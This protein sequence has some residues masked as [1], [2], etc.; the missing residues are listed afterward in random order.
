MATRPVMLVILDGFGWREE[1]ADN[2]V[3]QAKTPTFTRLWESGPHAFLRTSGRDVGLPDGQMGNS[4]VGHLNIGAGRVVKQ[5]LVRIGDA[6]A[7]GSIAKMPAFTALVDALN[8]SGGTC[9]LIGLVSPGGVHSHQDHAA[10]IA[11]YLHKAGIR[12]V[13]HAITDGRDTPPQSAAE[14]LRRL[15]SALPDDVPVATVVGRY[16][17][18][19]RDKRWDRVAQAYGTIVE[20]AG[21]RFPSPEAAIQAAYEAKKFDEFVPASV[22]GD[23]AGMK[24]GDAILCFNFRADRVREIL[25]AMLDPAFDGFPRKR[26]LKFAAAVGMTHYSDA[27]APFL[28]VLFAAETLP[29]M[30]GEVVANAGKTQ[31]RMA[32]TE[33]FAHVTY[34]LNGGQETPYKSEDRIMVASPKVATYDLQ[35]E[36]SAPE[37]T[38]K[39]VEA[40]DGGKYDLIVLNFANPDM[41]GHTGVLAAAIKAV[42]TVDTGLGRIAEAIRRQGGA[43]LVTADHG[44]CELMKDPETG[45]PHTAHTTNPVPVVL[46]GGGAQSIQDGRLAD[47]APTLLDL[48]GIDQ[49]AEMTGHSII[50]R[51]AARAAE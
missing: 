12:T 40:I 47:L 43:L 41:V 19:D 6:V 8:Q 18:M 25:A 9:H 17:A 46:M 39:A 37:L 32:E 3:R 48:M 24:D 14:D 50:H 45:G 20:A 42:E 5:E 31:L 4:E 26:V 36:M 44:N 33:K 23:Y 49:P 16:F 51:Q 34:F 2:A 29:N 21:A 13:V 28:G 15:Q 11:G 22:I 35:P 30:L 10:A 1:T 7:D 38:D 27:L